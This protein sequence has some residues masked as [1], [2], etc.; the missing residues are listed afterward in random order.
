MS[1]PP[2]SL[3]P[4]VLNVSEAISASNAFDM[5]DTLNV[6]GSSATDTFVSF[7]NLS[8][9]SPVHTNGSLYFNAAQNT[10]TAVQMGVHSMGE[11][12]WI[13]P[14]AHTLTDHHHQWVGEVLSFDA[15]QAIVLMDNVNPSQPEWI[16][17]Q[18]MEQL[19]S[20]I[21]LKSSLIEQGLAGNLDHHAL[22]QLIA[23][24][25]AGLSHL[26]PVIKDVFGDLNQEVGSV[27]D[28]LLTQNTQFQTNELSAA[29]RDLSAYLESSHGLNNLDV[30]FT[31]PES[32]PLTLSM[33]GHSFSSFNHV[34]LGDSSSG[35]S[36]N[37]SE[38]PNTLFGSD[39]PKDV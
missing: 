11:S 37:A 24:L 7:E 38:Q 29:G 21:G 12:V 27:K 35:I 9:V 39:F 22:T 17:G 3:L 33:A 8:A 20:Q 31:S 25:N 2:N 14:H 13:P 26:T 16:G 34:L 15:N 32:I 6:Q 30:L 5:S 28:W 23:D 18:M 10:S 4:I 1:N 36:T 19:I